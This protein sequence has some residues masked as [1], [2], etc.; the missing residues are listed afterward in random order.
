MKIP[1]ETGNTIEELQN[2]EQ[3]L[4]GFLA[5]KQV[6]QVE[7]QEITNA[8][9]ELKKTHDEVYKIL[10][11]IMLKANKELLA[12]E[13]EEKKRLFELRIE[14]IEKQEKFLE[15]EAE[16]LKEK[17]RGLVDREKDKQ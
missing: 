9:E 7:L 4:Q 2:L 16:K 8:L 11:G 3:H 10:S 5:Q 12:K 15:E 13:L 1:K 14:A 17:I 6:V